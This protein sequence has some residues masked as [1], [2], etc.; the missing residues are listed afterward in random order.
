MK[1]LEGI[2]STNEFDRLAGAICAD[3]CGRN[4]NDSEKIVFNSVS[5]EVEKGRSVNEETNV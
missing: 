4:C 5:R 2:A 1:L 3:L